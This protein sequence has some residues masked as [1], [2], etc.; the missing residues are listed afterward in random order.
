M[1]ITKINKYNSILMLSGM[2]P[3]LPFGPSR[4]ILLKCQPCRSRS[5][6]LLAQTHITHRFS[7]SHVLTFT[8]HSFGQSQWTELAQA[9]LEPQA[10]VLSLTAPKASAT[11]SMCA[12]SHVYY[13]LDENHKQW[14]MA[15]PFEH[16]CNEK[17]W[18]NVK[19]TT[20]GCKKLSTSSFKHLLELHLTDASII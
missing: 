20:S 16:T 10:K 4:R 19:Y 11:A 9:N 18:N 6:V 12:F 14:N 13:I 3:S 5:S 2:H 7:W 15:R 8:C 17:M 1:R